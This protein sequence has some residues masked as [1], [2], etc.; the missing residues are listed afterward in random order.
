MIRRIKSILPVLLTLVLYT[1]A[2]AQAQKMNHDMNHD[3]AEHM[4]ML[5]RIADREE[6]EHLMWR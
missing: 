5:Q 4:A 6:I 2:S 1:A 3:M